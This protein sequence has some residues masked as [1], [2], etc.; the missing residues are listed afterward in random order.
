[1]LALAYIGRTF[2]SGTVR[3]IIIN[4]YMRKIPKYDYKEKE[5]VYYISKNGHK[6]KAQIVKIKGTISNLNR[7]LQ[8]FSKSAHEKYCKI[9]DFRGRGERQ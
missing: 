2:V 4:R 5:K 8:S 9:R 3:N 6:L 7:L 1:M